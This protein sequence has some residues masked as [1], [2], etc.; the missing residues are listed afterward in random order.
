MNP[1]VSLAPQLLSIL[2]IVTAATF[3]THGT[4]KIFAWPAPFP[5]PMG[6]MLYTAGV[7]EV[8]GGLLL[9]AGLFSRSTGFL[10]SGLMAFA[11]FIGH[12]STSFFPVLN[13]GEAALMFCFVFLYI[14]AAGPGPW[15]VDALFSNHEVSEP[16]VSP[17]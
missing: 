6:L 1:L 5:Y 12:G 16:A 13:G 14:S 11:Y 9:M 15:S 7:L 17:R 10:M 2:R 4:M 3:F 8:V